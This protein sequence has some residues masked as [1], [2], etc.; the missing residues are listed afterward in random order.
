[1]VLPN[2]KKIFV[3]SLGEENIYFQMGGLDYFT[4]SQKDFEYFE[5]PKWIEASKL[6]EML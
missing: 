3:T 1:M 2:Y 4:K 5:T 6:K